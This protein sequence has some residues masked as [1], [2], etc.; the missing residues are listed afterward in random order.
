M[1]RVL[2]LQI[3]RNGIDGYVVPINDLSAVKQKMS[4]L[5]SDVAKLDEMG[6]AGR[7]R[8]KAHYSVER[9]AKEITT[10]LKTLV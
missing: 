3:I 1:K 9:E 5:L 4:L 10:F 2:G 8:V 7:Q 6:R